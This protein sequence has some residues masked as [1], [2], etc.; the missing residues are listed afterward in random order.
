MENEQS[1]ELKQYPTTIL[2][3]KGTKKM[4][5]AFGER[6]DSYDDIVRK[7]MKENEQLKYALAGYR[8]NKEVNNENRLKISHS[9]TRKSKFTLRQG[10]ID[11]TYDAPQM[12]LDKDFRFNITCTKMV[13]NNKEL[14]QNEN[15]DSK[16]EM[17]KNHLRIIEKLIKLH[18]DP[19]FKINTKHIFDLD[20]WERMF[21]NLGLSKESYK[22]DIELELI[23]RGIMP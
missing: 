16:I 12:P 14:K 2:I 20:W 5:D 9:N 21:N 11:F 18:I 10:Y 19:L 1:I 6:R 23:K 15:Y 8:E 7:L 3:K 17:A 22:C 4:L 13:L